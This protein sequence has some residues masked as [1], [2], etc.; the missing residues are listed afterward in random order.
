M[1]KTNL[2]HFIYRAVILTTT[3][4]L[5]ISQGTAF[6]STIHPSNPSRRNHIWKLKTNNVDMRDSST[7]TRTGK[8]IADSLINLPTFLQQHQVDRDL[9]NI[10]CQAAISC[11]EIYQHLS[12]LPILS[13]S[14]NIKDDN[15]SQSTI[16]IQGEVQKPMDIIANEI[17][18]RNLEDTVAALA[19]EEESQ[20]IPGNVK[21]SPTN[22]YEIAFDPL[23]G[24]SN[25]D[26][27]VPTGSIFGIAPHIQSSKPFT[28]SGRSLIAA[29]Y[30]V[31]SSSLEFVISIGKGSGSIAA[32]FTYC[33]DITFLSSQRLTPIFNKDS[34]NNMAGQFILSRPNL[35][36]PPSG[37]FYSLNDGREPDWPDGLRRWIHDAKR[38]QTP[39]G[40]IYSSRYIC[41]LCADFHRTLIYG[42]WCGNPRPHLRLLY[43]AAPL[44]HIVEACG[45]KGSDGVMSLLDLEPESLHDRTCVFLGSQ[46]DIVELEG[47]GNVQQESK[48][49]S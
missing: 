17:F 34:E 1:A 5:F 38:G 3:T 21:N 25:L 7:S 23:D 49:Y 29:G 41:S 32:G 33:S 2:N 14:M 46:N 39:S 36:C 45:G 30:A 28:T 18:I 15:E 31:Y 47:Y 40:T 12:I 43:E 9:S 6:I 48:T 27:S 44:A 26:V 16:N 13:T 8:N 11:I 42:G 22:S 24:S 19:S 10:I 20:V 35:R 37:K 4:F